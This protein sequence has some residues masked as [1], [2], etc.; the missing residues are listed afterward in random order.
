MAISTDAGRRPEPEQQPWSPVARRLGY[1]LKHANLRFADLSSAALAP[2]GI[3]GRELAVLVSLDEQDPLSQ[4]EAARRLGIDRT[5][6]VAL[7]DKLEGKGLAERRRHADDR[8]RN[9]VALTAAGR[10]TLRLA[11][12]AA[13]DAE[14]RFLEPLSEAE[15]RRFR[16]ALRRL[17]FEAAK[18][19]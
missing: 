15:A 4:R 7:V 9:L 11:S 17:V 19:P 13:E 14:R 16:N 8:R 12:V 1:L 10:E 2:Y 3:D 6:M 5:T 18:N